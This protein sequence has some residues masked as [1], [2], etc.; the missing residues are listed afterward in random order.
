RYSLLGQEGFLR[1]DGSSLVCSGVQMMKIPPNLGTE[2]AKTHQRRCTLMSGP[3]DAVDE[4]GDDE[5]KNMMNLSFYTA[6]S[7][8]SSSALSLDYSRTSGF[9]D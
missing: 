7:Q 8:G 2:M 9:F 1:S 5:D 6:R 4:I 3:R